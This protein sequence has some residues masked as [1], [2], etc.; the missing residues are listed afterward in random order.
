MG[1]IEV[2]WTGSYPCLCHGEWIIIINGIDYSDCIPTDKR[3]SDMNTYGEYEEWQF[4]D[5]IE[6]FSSYINGLRFDEWIK[7]ND[8]VNKITLNKDEQR[9]IFEAIQAE[10]WRPGSCGGCI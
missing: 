1:K 9:N 5:G 6:E 10:D 3:E 8:W 2:K 7:E 4:V